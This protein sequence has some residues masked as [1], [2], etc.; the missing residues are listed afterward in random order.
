MRLQKWEKDQGKE[1][2]RLSLTESAE[3]WF[4]ALLEKERADATT[5]T[6]GENLEGAY[7]AFRARYVNTSTWLLENQLHRRQQG[8]TESVEAYAATMRQRM[9]QLGKSQTEMLAL[10]VN[11]LREAIKQQVI[12]RD[13]KDIDDREY[14]AM[15]ISVS[16]QQHTPDSGSR[17][18]GNFNSSTVTGA[19]KG[20]ARPGRETASNLPPRRT[21]EQPTDGSKIQKRQGP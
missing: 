12:L 5:T 15:W 21:T 6:C 13:S 19:T 20:A 7:E 2:F 3:V 9:A 18:T 10:F 17:G 14:T 4:E 16:Y 1:A 11:S 8:P